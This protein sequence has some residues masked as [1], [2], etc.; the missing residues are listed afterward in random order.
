MEPDI[1]GMAGKADRQEQHILAGLLLD[2]LGSGL[3]LYRKNLNLVT[4]A[5]DRLKRLESE[6]CEPEPASQAERCLGQWKES[7]EIRK[8]YYMVS[9]ADADAEEQLLRELQLCLQQIREEHLSADTAGI[10]ACLQA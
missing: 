3:A 7:L 6:L 4:L 5:K 10:T 2:S 1:A 8:Q 9:A